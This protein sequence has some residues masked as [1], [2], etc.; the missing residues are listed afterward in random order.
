MSVTV[1][2][3]F[4]A[5]G[6]AAGVSSTGD[7]DVAVVVNDGPQFA[8]GGVFT[9]AHT[10][11]APVHFSARTT[12]AAQIMEH[13]IRAVVANSGCANSETGTDGYADVTHTAAFLASRLPGATSAANVLVCSSGTD[14]VAL[15]MGE[16][17]PGVNAAHRELADTAEANAAAA[18]ALSGEGSSGR[19]AAASRGGVTVGGIASTS[20]EIAVLTTDAQVSSDV[21]QRVL[22]AACSDSFP[23]VGAPE[24]AS[25]NAS[26]V[27]LANGASETVPQESEFGL[28]VR[29][30][31]SE[32]TS[33]LP[34]RK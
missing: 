13:P 7:R 19:S 18:A 28:L 5:A 20:G 2:Q 33:E 27:L 32:L 8:A 14:G 16:L 15:P 4:R 1:A 9:R 11:A 24:S 31:C 26:V 3:G 23:W 12:E 29:D 22:E 34:T 6:V 30:V 21:L 25:P 10:K 17:L